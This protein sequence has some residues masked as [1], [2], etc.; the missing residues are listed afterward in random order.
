ML[1]KGK[2]RSTST[3]RDDNPQ[4]KNKIYK[5]THEDKFYIVDEHNSG[6]GKVTL[7]LIG[8]ENVNDVEYLDQIKRI[9]NPL[10]MSIDKLKRFFI[11]PPFFNIK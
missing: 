2:V 3:N 10:P 9:G 5:K 8:N 1:K 11:F 4:L 7:S 6:T